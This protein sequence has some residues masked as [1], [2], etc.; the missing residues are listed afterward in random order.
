MKLDTEVDSCLGAT[1]KILSSERDEV[2]LP[3]DP[4]KTHDA[5]N[6]WTYRGCTVAVDYVML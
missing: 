2:C 5:Y 6:M 1:N 3:A 4:I